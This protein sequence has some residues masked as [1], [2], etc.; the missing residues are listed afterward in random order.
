MLVISRNYD[1]QNLNTEATKNENLLLSSH[2]VILDHS[3]RKGLAR[4]HC[5]ADNDAARHCRRRRCAIIFIEKAVFRAAYA[6][7]LVVTQRGGNR[8][9]RQTDRR[10][11]IHPTAAT[12]TQ[13]TPKKL[14]SVLWLINLCCQQL[15]CAR[16]L[17]FC[18][19]G[20]PVAAS[21]STV[22]R[23]F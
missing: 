7:N 5:I 16:V 18:F 9:A 2:P 22:G 3:G 4:T 15:R 1:E 13:H 20:R 21:R 14:E 12:T 6:E 10:T 19:A 11:D 17:L 8:H 23:C